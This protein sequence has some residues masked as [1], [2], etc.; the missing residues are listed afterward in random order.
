M[1][2]GKQPRKRLVGVAG[3]ILEGIEEIPRSLANCADRLSD[4]CQII[5]MHELVRLL[6][7]KALAINLDRN[8]TDREMIQGWPRSPSEI[9]TTTNEICMFGVGRCVD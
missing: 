9:S 3:S 1:S 7:R 4:L 8:A 2:T 6:E 5:S